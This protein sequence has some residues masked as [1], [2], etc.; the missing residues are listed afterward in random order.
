ML[1]FTNA[2]KR[3]IEK[4]YFIILRETEDYIEIKS[5]NTKHLWI[6]QKHSF[7]DDKKIYLYH[8]HSEKN[9]YY[10]KHWQ[11]YTVRQCV[12]SIKNHDKYV[13]AHKH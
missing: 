10:H 7:V 8:K 13:I 2:E 4:N 11:C 9:K 3:L 5:K 12:G 6:I 1:L